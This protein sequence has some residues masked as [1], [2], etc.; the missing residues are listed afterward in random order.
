MMKPSRSTTQI[1]LVKGIPRFATCYRASK[2][3]SRKRREESL[4]IDLIADSAPVTNRSGDRGEAEG[5]G[6]Q[7][8]VVDS[9]RGLA[10]PAFVRSGGQS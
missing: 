5:I 3:C 10:D 1:F 2:W 4:E 8:I 6:T 9:Q 7:R